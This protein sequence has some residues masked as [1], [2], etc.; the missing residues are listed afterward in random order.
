M[1]EKHDVILD[2]WEQ[3]C[4]KLTAYVEQDEYKYKS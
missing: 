1:L 4:K 3:Q 2:G